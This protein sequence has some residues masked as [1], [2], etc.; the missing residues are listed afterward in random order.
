MEA[1]IK[2]FLYGYG[3][4]N[5]YGYGY[6][7]VDGYGYGYGYGNVDGNGYGYGNGYGNGNGNGNGYGYGYGNV[8]GN[9][10]G[11]GNG[12]GYGNGY[13]N[14]DGNGYGNG[15]CICI[16]FCKGN[17]VY[18]IDD[19]PCI[20]KRVHDNWAEVEVIDNDDF[21][22]KKA[23]IGKFEN[24]FAHGS[25]IREALTD[26][27]SKYYSSLDFESVKEKLLSEFEVKKRLTVKEL[28]A[29]H[30]ALTGSCR[31][32][33]DEFQK[34]HNLRDD[35]TLSLDEFISLTENAFGGN[36]VRLLK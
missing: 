1:E 29:W 4:G 33:R 17:K 25:T 28:Y 9:V 20:F 34:S 22:T 21:T 32:G 11:N 12:N 24:T 7:N 15:D 5:G 6:G 36:K 3:Y 27:M 23:F 8:D 31:F 18:Y 26:A 2:K 10:D 13:G 30:G 19:F 16:E 35:D 14:V